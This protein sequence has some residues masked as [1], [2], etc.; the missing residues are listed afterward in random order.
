LTRLVT[1]GVA[2]IASKRQRSSWSDLSPAAVDDDLDAGDVAAFAES[3]ED[4]VRPVTLAIES[5][6]TG[7]SEVIELD[8]NAHASNRGTRT[9]ILLVAT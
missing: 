2:E 7:S 3:E 1:S 5:E 4:V 6:M 8:A 9:K